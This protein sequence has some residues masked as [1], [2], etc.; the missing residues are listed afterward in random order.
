MAIID[1]Q[2]RKI[3]FI[4]WITVFKDGIPTDAVQ[5][6]VTVFGYRNDLEEKPFKELAS[7]ALSCLTT[8]TSNAVV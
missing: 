1:Y 2:Y 7:Y 3:K 6:W 5:F 4:D 8:P